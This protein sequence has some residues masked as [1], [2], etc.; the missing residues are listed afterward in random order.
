MLIKLIKLYIFGM[1]SKKF[2]NPIQPLSSLYPI[3]PFTWSQLA[4]LYDPS[5]ITIHKPTPK[6]LLIMPPNT[7]N[8]STNIVNLYHHCS[9]RSP[10]FLVHYNI[11]CWY[12]ITSWE[13][14]DHEKHMSSPPSPPTNIAS[15]PFYFHLPYMGYPQKRMKWK[16]I[17]YIT[18][19]EESINALLTKV[20][21]LQISIIDF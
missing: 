18:K 17:A 19:E 13:T 20:C 4:Q 15:N 6:R 10:N 5:T 9:N 8:L 14:H 16:I 11:F 2:E 21:L 3:Y 7:T 1:K 12:N